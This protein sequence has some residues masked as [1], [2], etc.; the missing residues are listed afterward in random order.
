MVLERNCE[1]NV[2]ASIESAIRLYRHP[3]ISV[4]DKLMFN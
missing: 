1:K 3:T 2:L 4:Q